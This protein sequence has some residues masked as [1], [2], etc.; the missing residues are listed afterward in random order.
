MSVEA[1]RAAIGAAPVEQ[2]VPVHEERFNGVL[3]ESRL[4]I[5]EML[6]KREPLCKHL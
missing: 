3:R 1:P 4:L 6:A 5:S 2:P